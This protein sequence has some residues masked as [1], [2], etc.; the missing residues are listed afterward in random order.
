M[1]VVQSFFAILMLSKVV[2]RSFRLNI[3]ACSITVC[4][5][6][7]ELIELLIRVAGLLV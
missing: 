1:S 2:E 4:A 5:H 3:E 6:E 7:T